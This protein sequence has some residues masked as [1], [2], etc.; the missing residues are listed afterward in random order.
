MSPAVFNAE[1]RMKL[2]SGAETAQILGVKPKTLETWRWR[3]I[4]PL[5]VRVGRLV[6]YSESDVLAWVAAQKRRS[7]SDSPAASDPAL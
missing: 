6:K 5:F 3:G 1:K 7:T 2:L 4:G